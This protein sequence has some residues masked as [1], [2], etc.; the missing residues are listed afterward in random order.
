[1]NWRAVMV[2][3]GDNNAGNWDGPQQAQRD[4]PYRGLE[5]LL[6]PS[7]GTSNFSAKVANRRALV[8][9]VV[10]MFGFSIFLARSPSW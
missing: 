1:M 3:Y 10:R 6:G 7:R 8:S 5:S 4:R 2:R 9:S